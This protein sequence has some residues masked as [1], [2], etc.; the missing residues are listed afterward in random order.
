MKDKNNLSLDSMP[1]IYNIAKAI[2][3]A[4]LKFTKGKFDKKSFGIVL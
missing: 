1:V 4:K 3:E 2:I